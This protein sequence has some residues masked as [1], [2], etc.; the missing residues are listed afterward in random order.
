MHCLFCDCA[1]DLSPFDFF[2]QE[3]SNPDVIVRTEAMNKIL[4]IVS[5]MGPERVRNEM[6]PYLQSKYNRI[7]NIFMRFKWGLLPLIIILS[8]PLRYPS[9]S[10][11]LIRPF[12]NSHNEAKRKDLN[13]NPIQPHP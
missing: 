10:H 8:P 13:P 7:E 2:R 3:T 12:I 6:L 1:G 5:L 4:V 11:S 9:F